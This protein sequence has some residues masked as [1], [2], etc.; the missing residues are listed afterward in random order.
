M[1]FCCPLLHSHVLVYRKHVAA[2][3]WTTGAMRTLSPAHSVI[4]IANAVQHL[5]PEPHK[6]PV[7]AVSFRAPPIPI[8][9][10]VVVPVVV[11]ELAH[12]CADLLGSGVPRIAG[13]EAK[14]L[15]FFFFLLG[16]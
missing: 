6:G 5:V 13:A 1:R 4:E 3:V 10:L 12:C 7:V 8:G 9:D 15:F 16:L 11:D 14:R 2:F